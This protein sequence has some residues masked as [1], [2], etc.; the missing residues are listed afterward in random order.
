MIQDRSKWLLSYEEEVQY[1]DK[2]YRIEINDQITE[3]KGENIC[4]YNSK[5]AKSIAKH[6]CA[7]FWKY[8][9]N[10]AFPDNEEKYTLSGLYED[11]AKIDVIFK[12]NKI[13]AS[14]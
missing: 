10:F 12:E 2:N 4:K 1:L 5:V 13:I 8:I 3:L 7:E 11:K 14:C 6:R 9:Y